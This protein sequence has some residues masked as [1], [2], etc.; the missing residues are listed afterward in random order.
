MWR[1]AK[2]VSTRS[3][4]GSAGRSS[5]W[6]GRSNASACLRHDGVGA[7][8]GNRTLVVS[9]EGFCSTIELHPPARSPMPL[10][11]AKRQ[12]EK[13]V[14]RRQAA[15]LPSDSHDQPGK[16]R[17]K[18]DRSPVVARLHLRGAMARLID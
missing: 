1:R 16:F 3:N 18:L 7:G 10:P 13:G 11:S 14:D 4:D 15:A 2:D 9:L 6:L 17:R 5:R 12:P 8:E